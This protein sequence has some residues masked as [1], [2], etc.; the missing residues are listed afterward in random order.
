MKWVIFDLDKVVQM[1]RHNGIPC[2]QV[3][4]GDF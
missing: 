1:W 4:P 3:A 2:F